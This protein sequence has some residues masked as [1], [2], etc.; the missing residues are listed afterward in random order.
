MLL[1]EFTRL[2]KKEVFYILLQSC[3]SCAYPTVAIQGTA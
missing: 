3:T 2:Q 1:D